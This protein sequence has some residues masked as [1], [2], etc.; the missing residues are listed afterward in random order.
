MRRHYSLP[1]K[2]EKLLMVITIHNFSI[3]IFQ[4]KFIAT[5]ARER[6]LSYLLFV[7][8]YYSAKEINYIPLYLPPLCK[9]SMQ[10]SAL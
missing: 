2:Y 10:I 3:L 4:I 5:F 9:L 7:K 1:S 8:G 6:L